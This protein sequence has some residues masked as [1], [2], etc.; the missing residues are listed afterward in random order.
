MSTGGNKLSIY[1][2]EAGVRAVANPVRRKILDLLETGEQSFDRIV[3]SSG[4]A[5]ST[6]SA[7][8]SDLV[9][10]GIV[11][12]RHGEDDE[13]KKYFFLT[14]R[15]IG[16]FSPSDR[17]TDELEVYA[18]EY[19]DGSIDPFA[20]YKLVYR[21]FRVSLMMEGISIDPLL[22][23]C[24]ESVGEA[25]YPAVFAADTETLLSNLSLFWEHHQLGRIHDPSL[26]PLS[27][28]VS[29]CFE[30]AELP[31][32]GRP[33]CSFDTGLL[34]VI[35]SKHMGRTVHAVERECYAA[36][37]SRCSFEFLFPDEEE[38]GE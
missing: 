36:G 31:Q 11:G 26:E 32:L 28:S 27:F 12:S 3:A 21:I 8:L 23:R 34:S 38:T 35:F 13:R 5:K 4:R 37:D 15:C 18:L 10:E 6:I 16:S 1:G 7:H 20:L 29:N 17:L 22:R 30:C 19:R 24:G 14:S 25:I 2:T 33:A 9:D